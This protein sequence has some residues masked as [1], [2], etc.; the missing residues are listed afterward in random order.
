M[1]LSLT[2]YL[3]ILAGILLAALLAFTIWLSRGPV[4]PPSKHIGESKGKGRYLRKRDS[5]EK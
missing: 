4:N 2:D 3:L 5:E 1:Q